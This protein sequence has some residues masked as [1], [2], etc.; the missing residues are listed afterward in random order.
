MVKEDKTS[1]ATKRETWE[2]LVAREA[3]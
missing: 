2:D 3:E 1:L